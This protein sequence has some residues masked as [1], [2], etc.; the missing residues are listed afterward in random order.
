MTKQESHLF[1]RIA[2]HNQLVSLEDA[3]AC[4]REALAAKKDVSGI[5]VAEGLLTQEQARKIRQAVAKK[6]AAA[7]RQAPAGG[8][9]PAGR[10]R[11]RPPR[12]RR[13]RREGAP[14]KPQNTSQLVLTIGSFAVLLIV[15]IV[16]V[17][18]WRKP[19]T[20]EQAESSAAS[21]SSVSSSGDPKNGA[22]ID[23]D[24]GPDTAGNE[25]G[26]TGGGGP[27]DTDG[28][29]DQEKEEIEKALGDALSD[30]M[31]CVGTGLYRNGISSLESFKSRY[32]GVSSAD[33]QKRYNE[34]RDQ[35]QNLIKGKFAKDRERLVKAKEADDASAM[36]DIT[37]EINEYADKETMKE[38]NDI[39]S[40]K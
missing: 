14:S 16:F 17:V 38:V 7:G 26:E 36:T 21:E 2:I 23:L 25:G 20:Q 28:M 13:R 27:A 31:M 15:A 12:G 29:P 5:F 39:I 3:N 33:Q 9:A 30:A 22:D 1:C 34:R 19:T 10:S 8:E 35:I 11:E 32:W 24:L 6:K 40:G 4:L 37:R 18:M